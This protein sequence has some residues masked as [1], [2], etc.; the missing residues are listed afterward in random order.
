MT[1]S[2][3]GRRRARSHKRN[4]TALMS[5]SALVV[6]SVLFFLGRMLTGGSDSPAVAKGNTDDGSV[7]G[8][9]GDGPGAG[10]NRRKDEKPWDGKVEVLGDG[11]TSYT[12]PQPGQLKP[13]KLK[14]GQ[15]PPQFV[16]FSWDGALEGDDHLF[17]HFRQ[18][19]KESDAH[20]TFFLT[21]IY[22][23]PKTKSELYDPPQHNRGAAAISYPTD[24][25]IRT[26]L[27]QLGGAWKDG[28]EIGSH[29][30]GH[31][32]G[33]GGGDDWSVKE[34]KSE[35]RQTYDFVKK[36]K[37]NTAF[38]DM[39]PLPFD[40]DREFVGGRAPCLEGQ[41][42]LI[43]ASKEFDWR[44]D[45]SSPGGFQ[46]WPSKKDGIWDFPLQL[47]PY[48]GKDI[49]V[50]SMDFNFLYNQS[51]GKTD[52]DPA[53]YPTWKQT[54]KDAYSNGFNRVYNGSRAPL[55]IGNH[56]E[57]WNGGIYM[58]AVEELMRDV[59]P[60]KDVEC[61]SFKELTDWMDVQDPR[62]LEQLRSLDPGQAPSWK[63]LVK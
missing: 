55:F 42:T 22:L 8:S 6:V 28:H 49:Q 58:E 31:F 25:H 47:L 3:R 57:Q 17:S 14:P 32:C 2:T 24:E 51:E 62:V 30:N 37:S 34:W 59:C 9:K 46:V 26:T 63:T 20:M 23:L 18:V 61:V 48:P 40:P 4:R 36:W 7:A 29:F 16:V 11:S 38:T 52:G 41:K 15:K 35:I 27:T 50:L 39:P 12:G 19:A 60:R 13:K 44:Y 53:Q 33:A 21:G 5:V 56:F 10:P 54:T 45:A 43:P 1:R